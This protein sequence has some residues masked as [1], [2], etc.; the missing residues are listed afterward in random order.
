MLLGLDRLRLPRSMS[1]M[2]GELCL[3]VLVNKRR[4]P[5]GGSGDVKSD[6]DVKSVESVRNRGGG[7]TFEVDNNC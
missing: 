7:P 5:S 2:G 6:F 3:L 4:F 1:S